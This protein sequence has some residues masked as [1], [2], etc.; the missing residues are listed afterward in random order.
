M[1]VNEG[2]KS[3]EFQ[4]QQEQYSRKNC[5]PVHGIAEEKR[6]ITDEVIINTLN[7]K[8]DLEITLQ[9]IEGT[10]RIGEPEKLEEKPALLLK[11]IDGYNDRN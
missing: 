4:N 6:E 7:K 1:H 9:G 11:I 2:R 5:L 3:R 8:L 10:H